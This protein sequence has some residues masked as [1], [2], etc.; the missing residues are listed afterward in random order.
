MRLCNKNSQ[1]LRTD[2]EGVRQLTENAANEA[3][4]F[5]ETV[6]AQRCS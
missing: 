1:T 6:E 4:E 2:G 5:K 3:T